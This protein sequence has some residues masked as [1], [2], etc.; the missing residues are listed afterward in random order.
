MA[1]KSLDLIERSR[2]ILAMIHPSTVRGV[3][4]RRIDMATWERKPKDQEPTARQESLAGSWAGGGPNDSIPF[5][6]P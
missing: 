5:G 2:R 6:A 3:A 1:Q 4:Y